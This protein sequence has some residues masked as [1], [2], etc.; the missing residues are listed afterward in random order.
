MTHRQALQDT[1]KAPHHNNNEINLPVPAG[2]LE[3]VVASSF[4]GERTALHFC[5]TVCLSVCVRIN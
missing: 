4:I 2:S 1:S 5:T 3:L